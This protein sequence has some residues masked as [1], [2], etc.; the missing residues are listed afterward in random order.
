MSLQKMVLTNQPSKKSKKE[1]IRPQK[2]PAGLV[3]ADAVVEGA[4]AP[5]TSLSPRSLR[6]RMT[7]KKQ[8]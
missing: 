4:A 2:A 6:E 5:Q 1:L 8:M 7:K 3:V